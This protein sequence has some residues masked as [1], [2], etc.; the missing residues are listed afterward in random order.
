M[1]VHNHKIKCVFSHL[2]RNMPDK[3]QLLAQEKG[4]YRAQ[5]APHRALPA[6]HMGLQILDESPE[7]RAHLAEQCTCRTDQACTKQ[8]NRTWL[9]HRRGRTVEVE[10]RIHESCLLHVEGEKVETV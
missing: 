3:E 7:L 8:Q 1:Q 10:A 9:R 6:L 2:H 5:K 4:K